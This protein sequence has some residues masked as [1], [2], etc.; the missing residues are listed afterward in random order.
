MSLA[1]LARA[2]HITAKD[3]RTYYVKPPLIS[4]G[5]LFPAV[6]ILAFY[7]REPADI[8]TIAPGLIG[9]TVLFGAT[10]I[11]A[12][13][14]AF[15]KRIGALERLLMAPVSIGALVIG[16]VAAASASRNRSRGGPD[17]A[18]EAARPMRALFWIGPAAPSTPVASSRSSPTPTTP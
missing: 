9:M 2:W 11:E 12:V 6:L 3:V 4:W 5:M 17:R 14:I 7:L 13:V 16:S 8:R 10:S 15:E 1:Q 18:A